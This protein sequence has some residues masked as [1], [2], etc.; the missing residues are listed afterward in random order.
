MTEFYNYSEQLY[1]EIVQNVESIARKD[2]VIVILADNLLSH[3][4]DTALVKS[5]A[6][7]MNANFDIGVDYCY[8]L[9]HE[10]SHILYGDHEAQ[11]VYQ[12]SEF[13][14]RGEELLAHRN[15]IRMLMAIEMPTT[16]NDF[17][18]FYHVPSW[19]EQ[20]AVDVYQDLKFYE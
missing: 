10:L 5:R 17:M 19:L 3:V 16:V 7:I 20:Y 12:F 2:N 1:P 9:S 14:K 15:A 8:R 18:E 4:P 6:I 13:G 11:A